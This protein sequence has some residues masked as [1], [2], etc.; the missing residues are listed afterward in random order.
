M[1]FR[2]FLWLFGPFNGFYDLLWMAGDEC[3]QSLRD[4]VSGTY[5][6]KKNAVALGMG[7]IRLVNLFCFGLNLA[8]LEVKRPPAA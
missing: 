3:R 6:I 7:P 8:C 2:L 1:T 4:K 5:V